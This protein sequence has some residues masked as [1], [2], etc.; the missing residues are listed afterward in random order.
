MIPARPATKLRTPRR[1]LDCLNEIGA[2]AAVARRLVVLLDYDGTLAAIAPRPDLAHLEPGVRGAL[3][4]LSRQRHVR[5]AVISGRSLDD[6]RARVGLPELIYAGCHG[7]QIGGPQISFVE[8]TALGLRP[9]LERLASQLA[10]ALA[11]AAGVEVEDKGLAIAVHFRRAA[12]AA[13]EK[14]AAAVHSLMALSGE[15]FRL[16]GG[17]KIWE[18][19]PEVDWDKGRAARWILERT[20]GEDALPIYIGDDLTDEDAFSALPEGI[21]ARVGRPSRTLARYSLAGPAEVETFLGWLGQ[22]QPWSE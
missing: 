3:L 21:T 12:G 1:L 11:H 9:A 7:L 20:G 16:R 17:K 8:P 10:A 2:R 14:A 6:I 22:C 15:G 13:E 19:L 4:A 5:L 18:I